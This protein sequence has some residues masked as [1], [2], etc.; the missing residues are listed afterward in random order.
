MCKDHPKY[1]GSGKPISKCPTCWDIYRAIRV[2]ETAIVEV[3]ETPRLEVLPP[4]PKS[5][6]IWAYRR[7]LPLCQECKKLSGKYIYTT[8]IEDITHYADTRD[9]NAA[10]G[11][12]R[13]DSANA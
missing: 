4:Y 2:K 11:L 6:E 9:G 10:C 12:L 13:N 7:L 5:R 1:K 8:I 3:K